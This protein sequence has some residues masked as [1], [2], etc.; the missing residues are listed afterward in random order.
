[1]AATPRELR[2][3]SKAISAIVWN[4][5]QI[6][7]VARTPQRSRRSGCLPTRRLWLREERRERPTHTGRA[8]I[9]V[10]HGHWAIQLPKHLQ[11]HPGTQH[12]GLW[13][14]SVPQPTVHQRRRQVTPTDDSPTNGKHREGRWGY[15]D[16]V[17]G[18]LE[19]CTDRD[20]P[21]HAQAM[22]HAVTGHTAN[23]VTYALRDEEGR[24]FRIRE[25]EIAFDGGDQRLEDDEVSRNRSAGSVIS[26]SEG[27]RTVHARPDWHRS[28]LLR[29]G[30]AS[31]RV[32]G[33][34]RC[35]V[36]QSHRHSRAPSSRQAD[37]D[38]PCS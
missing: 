34:D 28:T 22:R 24:D 2:H 5:C 20:N 9:Q 8:N 4:A 32:D 25:A 1:M 10:L 23:H 38:C 17:A 11:R 31:E 18:Q 21:S 30:W 35:R 12:P 6:A 15:R 7:V 29:N 3:R 37:A 36:R 33:P 13:V 16:G 26:S 14:L 19:S 27:Y